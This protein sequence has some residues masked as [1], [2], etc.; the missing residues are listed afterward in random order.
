MLVGAM[1]T[2][3]RTGRGSKDALDLEGQ[4]AGADFIELEWHRIWKDGGAVKVFSHC[5]RQFLGY[6]GRLQGM[7][8]RDLFLDTKT[9]WSDQVQ[10]WSGA[11][12]G[13]TVV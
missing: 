3:M 12:F 7:S 6:F 9:H 13:K 5:I 11:V 1:S 10:R 4:G 8:K 2:G